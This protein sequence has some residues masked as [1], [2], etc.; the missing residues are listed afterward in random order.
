M[1]VVGQANSCWASPAQSFLVPGP[2]SPMTISSC[3]TTLA[4]WSLDA[5][6]RTSDRALHG[7]RLPTDEAGPDNDPFM[8]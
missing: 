3:L 4:W 8:H 2:T 6:N 1:L 7:I 5:L